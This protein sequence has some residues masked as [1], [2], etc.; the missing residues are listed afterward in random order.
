MANHTSKSDSFTNSI[1]DGVPW[2]A[3]LDADGPDGYSDT[4]DATPGTLTSHDDPGDQYADLPD[5]AV[6]KH[7]VDY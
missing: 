7:R 3:D 6:P 1:R 4:D 5:I 2:S